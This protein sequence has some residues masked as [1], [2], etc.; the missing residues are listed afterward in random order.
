M[1]H[2]S[3][4]EVQHVAESIYGEDWQKEILNWKNPHYEHVT[5]P[6]KAMV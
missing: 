6:A 4:I 3:Q 2:I 1:K 5:D